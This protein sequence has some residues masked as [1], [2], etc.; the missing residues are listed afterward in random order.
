[1]YI[2]I[3][4]SRHSFYGKI[5]KISRNL[6]YI[7]IYRHTHTNKIYNRFSYLFFRKKK[8]GKDQEAFGK[9]ENE[10]FDLLFFL[11]EEHS[12]NFHFPFW[13]FNLTF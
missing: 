2:I 13:N 10:S 7:Y 4:L 9:K 6:I 8:Q 12:P 11:S 5:R 1:M 3:F